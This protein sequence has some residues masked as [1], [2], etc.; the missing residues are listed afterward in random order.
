MKDR[1]LAIIIGLVGVLV[2]F[3][4]LGPIVILLWRLALT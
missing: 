3:L 2:I 1:T 4:I